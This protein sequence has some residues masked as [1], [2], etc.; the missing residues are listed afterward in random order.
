MVQP[1]VSDNRKGLASNR[2]QPL[3]PWAALRYIQVNN[4]Y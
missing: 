4:V 3:V 2:E 1:S